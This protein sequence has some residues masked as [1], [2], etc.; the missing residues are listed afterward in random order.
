MRLVLLGCPRPSSSLPERVRPT[1]NVSGQ[2][3]AFFPQDS[4]R[5]A[6]PAEAH[7]S[8]VKAATSASDNCSQAAM[9]TLKTSARS[10]YSTWPPIRADQV[11]KTLWPSA[12]IR[13]AKDTEGCVS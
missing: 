4:R 1:F 3:A 6:R 13:L 10:V 11:P 5:Q 9:E 12:A 7:T 2:V 8:E